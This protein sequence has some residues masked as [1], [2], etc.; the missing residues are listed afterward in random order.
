MTDSNKVL[1]SSNIRKAGEIY[2]SNPNVGVTEGE[3]VR[4]SHRVSA[5]QGIQEIR[6]LYQTE[7]RPIGDA[8][9]AYCAAKVYLKIEHI[10]NREFQLQRQNSAPTRRE[11][12]AISVED[13]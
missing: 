11:M 5:G 9:F 3:I 13:R 10:S 2:Y 12:R 8:S 7:G 1:G 4:I 6:A